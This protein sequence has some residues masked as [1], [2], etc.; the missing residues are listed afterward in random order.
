MKRR[1]LA[2]VSSLLL[3]GIVPGTTLAGTDVHDQTQMTFDHNLSGAYI[4]AQTFT[5][6]IDG[7]LDGV[8]LYLG[9]SPSGT[10]SVYATVQTTA[11]TPALPTGVILAS[12]TATSIT[13]A[14]GWTNFLFPAGPHIS[15]GQ[16]YAIVFNPTAN[17]ANAVAW[18]AQGDAYPRGRALVFS[19]G[20]WIA[21]TSLPTPALVADWSFQ[22]LVNADPPA[23]TPTPTPTRAPTPT[24]T[25]APTAAPTAAPT[26]TPAPTDT[27]TATA[28]AGAKS[29][30]TDSPTANPA[31]SGAAGANA[32]PNGGS[33]SGSGGSGD[34]TM[35][36]VVAGI[37]LAG[38]LGGGLVFLLMRHGSQPAG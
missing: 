8:L 21:P 7:T 5:A 29:A 15:A 2:L 30:A 33:G 38:L 17:T 13:G 16:V 14:G 23:P 37:V 26:P 4:K 22:T 25:P 9:T 10:S 20:S 31:A 1:A 35:L 28:T 18:G 27:P 34:S 19:A 24:R 32:A 12:R 11:G 3:V 6:G 36:I